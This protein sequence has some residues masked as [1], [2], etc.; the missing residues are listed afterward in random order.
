MPHELRRAAGGA[1]GAL[2]RRG[3]P[4]RTRPGA[5]PAV[6]GPGDKEKAAALVLFCMITMSVVVLTGWAGQVSLGQMMFVGFGAAVGAYA[7]QTWHLDLGHRDAAGRTGRRGR[8]PD[9][10][11]ARAAGAGPVPGRDHAGVLDGHHVL[12]PQRPA[13]LV[14]AGSGRHDR[15][16]EAVRRDRP[17]VPDELLLLLP[18]LPGPGRRRGA[19]HPPQPHRAGAAGA[20]RERA[21]RA[22]L[23][24]E[25]HPG[26]AHRLRHLRV[27]RRRG[28]LPAGAPAHRLQ[29]GHLLAL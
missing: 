23:R 16:P 10:R 21:G 6:L 28:R 7:T 19:G 11:T 8:R 13:L 18:R 26:Q 27:P 29:P 12:L 17:D 14:G 25:H 1:G 2:G 22:G 4:A 24:R 20:A 15:P 3:G 9:R 5:L